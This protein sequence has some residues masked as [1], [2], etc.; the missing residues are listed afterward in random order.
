MKLADA[1]IGALVGLIGATT[2]AM[3]ATFPAMPGQRIGPALFPGLVGAGL[4]VSGIGL[5]FSARRGGTG[6]PAEF[7]E[8]VRRP[9]MVLNAVLVVTGLFAYALVVVGLGYFVTSALLLAV[10]FRAFGVSASRTAFLALLVPVILHYMFYSLLRV[11]LPW[12]VLQGI[13][14]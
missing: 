13:A 6:T 9:R 7:G 8:G 2:L 11:P 5:V 3:S 10:L 4:L 12:G 1:L 14:W